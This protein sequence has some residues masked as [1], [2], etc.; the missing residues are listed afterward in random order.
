M[1]ALVEAS[2]LGARDRF[3]LGAYGIQEAL[4]RRYYPLFILSTILVS[5]ALPPG[6]AA[7]D[8]EPCGPP[9]QRA[10]VLSGG[11]LKGA[12]QAGAAYHLIVHRRC[13]FQEFAGVSVGSLNAVIL[14]QAPHDADP[15][16]SVRNLAERAEHLVRVWEG[17][18]SPKQVLKPR[19][20]GWRWAL[21][22]RF[23]F[24][25]PRTSSPSTR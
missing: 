20:P 14:A 6:T 11:G 2:L 24:S 21:F 19:W 13:D 23:G 17:I 5:L 25:A 9:A 12:F 7:Q 10:L 1:A 15:E 16:I 18:R 22:F 8:A 3:S 4:V